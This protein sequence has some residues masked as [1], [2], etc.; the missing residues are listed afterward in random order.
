MSKFPKDFLW[1]ASTASYQVEGGITNQWSKWEKASAAV[2]AEKAV[3]DLTWLPNYETL[4]PQLSDPANYISGT[5]VEHYERYAEDFDIL[6]SLHMNAFRFGVEWARLEPREGEWDEAAVQ[7]YR[8]YIT[9]LKSRGIEPVLNIWHWTMPL[10]F[11]AKGGFEKRGNLVLFERFVQKV[12]KDI[13]GDVR[14]IL[15]LNEPNVYASFSYFSGDWPPQRKRPFLMFKV[16]RHLALA[17]KRAY[18]ILKSESP[19]RQIGFAAQLGDTRSVYPTNL[20]NRV[21]AKALQYAWNWWFLNRT[22]NHLDFIGINY[23]FTEYRDWLGRLKNPSKPQSD[24]GWYMQPGGIYNILSN[25]WNRYQKPLVITE[26]GLA[27]ATDSQREWWLRETIAAIKKALEEGIGLFGYLHWS[28]LDNF[29]WAYGW[30]PKFGLV[31]IDRKTMKRT[32][33]PSAWWFAKQIK[34]YRDSGN[35]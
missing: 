14:Y 31:S 2:L 20:F 22:K 9:A 8:D 30:W 21:T 17:H 3:R 12:S 13:A 11:M 24:L 32:V 25:T 34:Q 5:G 33:R 18:V 15:T 16:Y 27:D 6:S 7:H 29:E 35:V 4:K 10:W 26:N 28:L 23:Y 19:E 1:G